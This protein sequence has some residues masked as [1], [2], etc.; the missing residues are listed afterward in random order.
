MLGV[1]YYMAFSP[2]VFAQAK[3]DPDLKLIATTKTWPAPGA[4]W[5]IYLIKDSPMVEPLTATPNVVASISSQYNWLN[6]NETWW[7]TPSL[8]SVYAAE[9][10]PANWP[11]ASSVTTMTKSAP[12]ASV[13]VSHVHIGLQSLSFHVSRVGVP[14]LVKISY[15]PRWHATGATGP[16]RVSPNLM[17]VVPTFKNVSLNYTST[18]ALSLGN[19]LSDLT[20]ISGLIVLYMVLRRRR[21]ASR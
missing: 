2:A 3:K 5:R 13:T 15:Y 7:L 4:Q 8:Q 16:Y 12:L 20:V 11:R 10:G 19:V 17:V 21:K 18:P 14:M 1:K 6:A 9:T